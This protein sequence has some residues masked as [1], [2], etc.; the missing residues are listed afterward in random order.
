MEEDDVEDRYSRRAARE[1][2]DAA[3]RVL[4]ER[5]VAAPEEWFAQVPIERGSQLADHLERA[6]AMNPCKARRREVR[7]VG[8]MLRSED[9]APLIEALD[10]AESGQGEDD[11]ALHVAE[12]WRE[13]LIDDGDLAL[14]AFCRAHPEADRQRMRQ[15]ARQAQKQRAS[16]APPKAARVLFQLIKGSL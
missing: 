5:L 3:G 16:K 6:R 2:E 9:R 11:D 14:D 8:R 1:V 13:R 4:A 15:L 12:D 7:Y 10:L